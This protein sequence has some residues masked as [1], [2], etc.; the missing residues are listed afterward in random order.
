V[1]HRHYQKCAAG[2]ATFFGH[3]VNAGSGVW[4]AKKFSWFEG[5]G[6]VGQIATAHDGSN[7]E[8]LQ[9]ICCGD[10]SRLLVSVPLGV[11]IQIVFAYAAGRNA[12]LPGY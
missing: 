9:A 7:P 3:G 4:M 1:Q 5:I 6:L 11:L 12:R 2:S 10:V 8:Y